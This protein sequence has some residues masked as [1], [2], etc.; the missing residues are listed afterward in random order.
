MT[1]EV[2]EYGL[3]CSLCDLLKIGKYTNFTI[4]AFIQQ[5]HRILNTAFCAFDLEA[6]NARINAH[7]S[8]TDRN[9]TIIY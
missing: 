3:W 6:T 7:G 9:K 1:R 8:D 2:I 4:A 5:T